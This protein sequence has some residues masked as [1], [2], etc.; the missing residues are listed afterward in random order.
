M[1]QDQKRS[2]QAFEA[3]TSASLSNFM[4]KLEMVDLTLQ[5]LSS[6]EQAISQ[7][8]M[9]QI[10]SI[11]TE[12]DRLLKQCVQVCTAGLLESSQK[13]GTTVLYS[14]TFDEARQWVGNLGEVG[15]DGPAVKVDHAEARNKS[16]QAMGNVSVEAARGFFR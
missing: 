10:I 16:R 15:A 8:D 6:A 4:G 3:S 9:A 7:Q 14:R 1:A 13:T 2:L 12:Q 5:S 11:L